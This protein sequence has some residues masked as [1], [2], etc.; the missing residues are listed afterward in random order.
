MVKRRNKKYS[1]QWLQEE[2][3]ESGGGTETQ[4]SNGDSLIL[5]G[6]DQVQF[7]DIYLYLIVLHNRR[8]VPA[9]FLLR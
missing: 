5:C 1:K 7:P 3:P 9:P 6:A 4:T 8:M 2:R